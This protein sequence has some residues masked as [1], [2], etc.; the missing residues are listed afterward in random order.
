[1]KVDFSLKSSGIH[2][3]NNLITASRRAFFSLVYNLKLQNINPLREIF[4][5]VQKIQTPFYNNITRLSPI[6]I[7][8][9]IGRIDF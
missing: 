9:V 7:L 8:S 4:I 1:M 6:K 3:N 5:A 2:A